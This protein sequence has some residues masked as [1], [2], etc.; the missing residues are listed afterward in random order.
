LLN[1][2][3]PDQPNGKAPPERDQD[4]HASWNTPIQGTA[5]EYCFA[6]VIALVDWL[7]EDAFPGELV[8]TIHDS[9]MLHLPEEC[10]EEAAWHVRRI[11]TGWPTKSG[12]PLEVDFKVGS[13][14][15]RMKKW[16]PAEAEAAERLGGPEAASLVLAATGWAG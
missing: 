15:G 4:E 10:V 6:S 11:M 9:V 1:L 16:Q 7:Q 12:V 5:S 3:L 2:G 14:W 8:V 13:S